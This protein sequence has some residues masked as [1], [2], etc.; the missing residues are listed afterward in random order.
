MKGN[1]MQ[2]IR[3]LIVEDDPDWLR[4]LTAYLSSEPDLEV[5]AVAD[6]S[7]KAL[8]AFEHY[9]ID[10]VL[11]D[12]MLANSTEGIWLTAEVTQN[13]GARVIMLTSLRE[14]ETIFEAFQAGAIDYIVKSDF[15][16]IPD[17]VRSAYRNQS[18]IS[19][20]AAEKMREEFLRLK[21]LERE[22]KTRELKNLLTPTEIEILRRIERG[23]TQPQ[24]AEEFVV[25][26]R[27]VKVH[28]GNILRKLGVKS[29]KD[30]AALA[31]EHGII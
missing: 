9:E 24:I 13:W 23:M 17:A 28:V 2:P 22:F 29:S 10:V 21:Q 18:P 20:E 11:M 14:K 31:K 6:T 3:I 26:I 7:E 8:K 12:I 15:E 16:R 30:A 5:C 19:P 1:S 25:S 4:G 27:T